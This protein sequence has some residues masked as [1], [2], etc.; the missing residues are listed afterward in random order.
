MT[1][2]GGA[3]SAPESKVVSKLESTVASKAG[4]ILHRLDRWTGAVF[5]QVR[6]AHDGVELEPAWRRFALAGAFVLIAILLSMLVLDMAAIRLAWTLPVPVINTF[7]E[8]T[9]FGQSH[10]PLVPLGVA[11][12]LTAVLA[13][14]PVGRMG[15][16]VLVALAA[17]FGFMFVAIGLP[18]LLVTIIK[19][20]IGRVRPSELGPFA[21]EPLSWKA[22]FASLPSGHTTTAFAT[23]VAVGLIVPRARPL[24]WVYAAA[25]GL[26]RIVVATHFPSDV[27]AGAAFGALGAVMVRDWFAARRLVFHIGSDGAVRPLPG[28]SWGRIKKVARALAGQ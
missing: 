8:I 19:R 21:Y 17:R 10:W 20:V 2:S 18:S 28:P 5:R 14:A 16:G 15:H 11:Y 13:A 7:N 6:S 23:L 3:H 27:M 26:S 1:A 22:Q 25:I 9:D 4:E 12:L 24:L